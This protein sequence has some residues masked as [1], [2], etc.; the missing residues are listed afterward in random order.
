MIK[1]GKL[2]RMTKERSFRSAKRWADLVNLN[3][4]DL[5]VFVGRTGKT[6][7]DDYILLAREQMLVIDVGFVNGGNLDYYAEEI[8]FS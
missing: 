1:I 7:N 5:F 6:D 3:K 2:Y 4:G 8:E